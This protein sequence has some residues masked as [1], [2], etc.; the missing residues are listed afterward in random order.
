MPRRRVTDDDDDDDD[1]RGTQTQTQ[2]SQ[3]TQ[4][5]STALT[6]AEVD[7]KAKEVVKYLLLMDVKKV[8]IKR[9]DISKNVMKEAGRQLNSV[10]DRATKELK[11]VFGLHLV[12][13]D[14]KTRSY[15]LVSELDH[16][17][18]ASHHVSD[19]DL[20]KIALLMPI[21]GERGMRLF[22]RI[23]FYED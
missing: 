3:A 9:A 1:Y 5:S 21:L 20:D 15:A 17:A 11:D 2:A 14:K 23:A 18:R 7:K 13:V 22:F 6:A 19:R 10:L 8:P 12:E 16:E 4:S